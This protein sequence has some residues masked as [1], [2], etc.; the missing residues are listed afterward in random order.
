MTVM[1][2]EKYL[3][4]I[5]CL[6][7]KLLFGRSNHEKT[8]RR[9]DLSAPSPYLT[10]GWL[11]RSGINAAS[12]KISTWQRAFCRPHPIGDQFLAWLRLCRQTQS[13]PISAGANRAGY[14]AGHPD[15]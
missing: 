5:V 14:L 10:N 12:R 6:F 8:I 4:D 7:S 11:F 9:S 3:D 13:L 1:S 15:A 2:L